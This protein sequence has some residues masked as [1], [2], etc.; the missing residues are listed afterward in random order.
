M[1]K[2]PHRGE[3]MEIVRRVDELAKKYG[4]KMSQIARVAVGEGRRRL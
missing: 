4:V 1:S 2:R 3:D